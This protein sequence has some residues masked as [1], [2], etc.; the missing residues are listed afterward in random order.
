M[1]MQNVSKYMLVLALCLVCKYFSF[2]LAG[3]I[4]SLLFKVQMEFAAY[5]TV[6]GNGFTV[7]IY[8][9]QPAARS[10]PI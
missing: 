4:C 8:P 2:V 7:V 5:V 1:R 3:D 10:T 6:T 9:Y